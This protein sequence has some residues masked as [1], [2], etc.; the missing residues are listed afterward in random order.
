LTNIDRS[1]FFRFGGRKCNKPKIYFFLEM[2]DCGRVVATDDQAA[3]S[4][5]SCVRQNYWN[6]D[7]LLKIIKKSPRRSP[8]IHS[9]YYVRH[10]VIS[11]ILEKVIESDF[12]QVIVL[13]RYD[14][15]MLNLPENLRHTLTNHLWNTPD[16]GNPLPF[17]GNSLTFMETIF[18]K[19]RHV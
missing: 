14:F 2:S 16:N 10:Q 8:I 3:L 17:N 7:F 1:T 15:K 19:T 6:D 11:Y 9:G 5:S 12:E 13:G 18:K 4:K